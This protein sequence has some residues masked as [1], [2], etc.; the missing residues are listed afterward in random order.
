ME[1]F[2]GLNHV[3]SNIFFS[4]VGTAWFDEY[5][6]IIA[7]INEKKKKNLPGSTKWKQVI[8]LETVE[9]LHHVIEHLCYH[10]KVKKWLVERKR[11]WNWNIV[12]YTCLI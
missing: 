2:R 8:M 7:T 5:E 11:G 6:V 12:V 9:Q 1:D 4:Q 3:L 10:F